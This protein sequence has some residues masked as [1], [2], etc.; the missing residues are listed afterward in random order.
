MLESGIMKHFASHIVKKKDGSWRVCV[1]KDGSSSLTIEDYPFPLVDELMDEM[2]WSEYFSKIE[3]RA[4]Y[5]HITV[6]VDVHKIPFGLTNVPATFRS[7][8]N[9]VFIEQL[10]NFGL[11][12]F[13]FFYDIPAYSPTLESDCIRLP[14]VLG[15]LRKNQLFAKWKKCSLLATSGVTGT[16]NYWEGDSRWSFKNS[17]HAN[18]PQLNSWEGS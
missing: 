7:L 10:R 6:R 11:V 3:L 18:Q 12:L 14:K 9:E 17:I 15:M 16:H 13:F 5:L 2:W 4:E 1:D 8:M